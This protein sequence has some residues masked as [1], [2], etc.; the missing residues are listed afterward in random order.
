LEL[1]LHLHYLHLHHLHLCHHLP[2]AG[3]WWRLNIYHALLWLGLL[4][5]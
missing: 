2:K 5:H 3:R 1:L 4:L